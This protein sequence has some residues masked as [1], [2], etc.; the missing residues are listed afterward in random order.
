MA[1]SDAE[2]KRIQN[3]EQ[4]IVDLSRAVNNLASK[5][6]LEQLLLIKQ[7]EIDQLQRDVESLE[8]QVAVLQTQVG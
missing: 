1:F 7:A 2:E 5:T 3:I 6:Q 8:A 4:A